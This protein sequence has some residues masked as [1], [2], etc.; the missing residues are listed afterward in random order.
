MAF[1]VIPTIHA[2]SLATC[3]LKV[4]RERQAR[5]KTSW[6]TSSAAVRQGTQGKGVHQGRELT[7]GRC[8]GVL[9]PGQ[10][11]V[12]QCVI[13]SAESVPGKRHRQLLPGVGARVTWLATGDAKTRFM[14][15]L[16]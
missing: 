11:G 8:Q 2:G 15:E 12:G 13:P 14:Q 7:V 5:M 9:I 16:R 1:R 6:V 3:G 10:E 4:L